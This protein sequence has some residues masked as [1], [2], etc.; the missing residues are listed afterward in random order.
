MGAGDKMRND[1]LFGKHFII[2]KFYFLSLHLYQE[3]KD[4]DIERHVINKN[5]MPMPPFCD[6]KLYAIM[7]KC[8]EHNL[9]KRP[10]FR[11]IIKM[12]LENAE[13]IKVPDILLDSFRKDAF[14]FKK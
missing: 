10:S 2:L 13:L 8:W 3:I 5:I 6:E 7:K 14:Y 4:D 1:P 11:E 9:E 12:L